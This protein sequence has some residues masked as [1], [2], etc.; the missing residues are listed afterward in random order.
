MGLFDKLF[1]GGGK[2]QALGRITEFGVHGLAAKTLFCG[3]VSAVD[4][5]GE[6]ASYHRKLNRQKVLRN[7][8]K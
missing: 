5:F 4:N 2:E 1:G 8:E 3:R 7:R 6:R